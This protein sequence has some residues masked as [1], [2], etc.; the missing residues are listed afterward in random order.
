MGTSAAATLFLGMVETPMIIRAYLTKLTRSE[1]FTVM[2]CGMSTV[3]GSVMIIYANTLSDIIP[4]AIG[5]IVVGFSP[6]YCWRDL[7]F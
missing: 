4:G 6:E 7:R 2:T 5:H 3:A 1:F